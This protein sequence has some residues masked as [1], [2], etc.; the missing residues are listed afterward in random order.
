MI[1]FLVFFVLGA[2]SVYFLL[3]AFLNSDPGKLSRIIK[4]III[5]IIVF[6]VL[7]FLSR[8]NLGFLAPLL[9]LVRRFLI[10][11]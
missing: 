9:G 3:R 11:V 7:F 8:G 1:K 5:I 4:T 6:G 2:A 10:G